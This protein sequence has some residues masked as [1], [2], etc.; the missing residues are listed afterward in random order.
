AAPPDAHVPVAEAGVDD[1]AVAGDQAGGDDD[2]GA[3][4]EAGAVAEGRHTEGEAGTGDQADADG[5]GRHTESQES[6]AAP[7]AD[8]AEE[9]VRHT[10]SDDDTVPPMPSEAPETAAWGRRISELGE[11][12]D[13]GYGM[14]SAAPIADGAQ[15]FAHPVQAYRD[16][17][18]FR[19]PQMPGY[20]SREPDVWFYDED[21]ALRSGFTY[22]QTG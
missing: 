22:S 19:T 11:V 4:D 2:D 8:G 3:G 14:G 18:T 6:E 10:E 5:P 13:G 9:E 7:S 21:S 15:P 17:M 20:D 1:E 12:R 16:T